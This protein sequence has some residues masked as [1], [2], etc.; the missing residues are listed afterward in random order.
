MNM[1]IRKPALVVYLA[2]CVYLLAQSS[3]SRLEDRSKF[4]DKQLSGR[5]RAAAARVLAGALKMPVADV[6]IFLKE[7]NAKPSDLV[8]TKFLERHGT[9]SAGKP[10]AEALAE[11]RIANSEALAFFDAGGRDVAAT[12]LP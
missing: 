6:E 1:A 7:P 8:F 9:R 10:F 5:D 12:G 2:L 4:L 11:A 3:P